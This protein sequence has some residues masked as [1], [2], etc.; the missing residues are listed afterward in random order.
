MA[1]AVFGVNHLHPDCN[2]QAVESA[3]GY[4]NDGQGFSRWDLLNQLTSSY[5]EKFT[6]AQAEYAVGKV[7]R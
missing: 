7:Y 2:A 3:K 4:L 5:G 1:D 6:Q